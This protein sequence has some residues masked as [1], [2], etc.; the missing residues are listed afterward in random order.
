MTL[1]S[2]AMDAGAFELLSRAFSDTREFFWQNPLFAK[3]TWEPFTKYVR[4]FLA[5]GGALA[6]LYDLRARRM[7]LRIRERTRRRVAWLFTVIA[8]GVFFDFGNPNT[9]YSEFYHRH[10]LYHYYLGSKYFSELGYLRM[11]EC[12]MVAEIENGH[13]EQVQTRDMRDLSVNLIKPV[14][15]SYAFSDPGRCTSHFTPP[16]WAAFKKDIEWFRNNADKDY[17]EGMQKDHGYNPPP[18]W[19]LTGKLF[20]N[21]HEASDGFF[22]FLAGL[23]VVLHVGILLLFRWAF[24][25]QIMA[26]AAVFWGTNAPADF[27][28]TGGAFLRQDWLFLLVAAVCCARKRHFLLAGAALT[29][30]ALLRVFPG[31]FGIGVTIIVGLYVL[32]GVRHGLKAVPGD[33]AR[34]LLAYLHPDHRRF[35]VGCL[36]ALGTLIPASVVVCG[37]ASYREFYQHTLRT[38]QNT[39]LTNHMGLETM[40]VHDWD[41]RMRFARDDNKDDAFQGWKQGRIDRFKQRK[42]VFFAIVLAVLAWTVWALRRT[43]LL[44][45]GMALSL[46]LVMSL[47]NLTNYYYSM[48]MIGA[49]LVAARPQFGVPFLVVSGI[50]KIFQYPPNGFYWLDD[51]WTAESWLCFALCLMM[52][53]VYSR[54]FSVERLKE[55]WA[56]KAERPSKAHRE[57][58]A[59]TAAEAQ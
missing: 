44:W 8:F 51:R 49:V 5:L 9:R 38:H 34:G 47:T 29:W 1:L 30:S 53:A 31:G 37:G 4:I 58:D 27:A 21:L 59:P 19:T 57:P 14:T 12:T 25:Y 3:E 10:E 35:L 24:G 39:P 55:W 26:I 6:L 45:L 18:V 15:A 54:P 22:K 17:W 41:G 23:D 28:F 43:K 46:P 20:S 36:V 11:Y 40:L 32:N 13:A 56:G 7:G 52:L 33:S 42:P 2:A 16:R 48:F 50:T